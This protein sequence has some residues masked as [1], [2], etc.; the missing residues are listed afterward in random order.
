M[1]GA[2]LLDKLDDAALVG[3]AAD[4]IGAAELADL[5]RL[6]LC[7]AAA[8]DEDAV[9]VEGLCAAGGVAGLFVAEGRHGAGI[10]DIDVGLVGK[11]D[12]L[13][14]LLRKQLLERLGL[15]LVGLAA[16]SIKSNFHSDHLVIFYINIAANAI[17]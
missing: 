8:D 5:I 15:K 4:D 9:G 14:P 6:Y 7:I 17:K 10:Y 16:E 13:M 1:V 2:G 3:R 12:D 11:G